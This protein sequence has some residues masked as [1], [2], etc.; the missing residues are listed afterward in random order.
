M[1]ANRLARRRLAAG[2]GAIAIVAMGT[3]SACAGEKK[4]APATTTTT[5]TTTTTVSPSE[6]GLSPSGVNKFTPS[7]K[8]PGPQT[9]LPGNVNTG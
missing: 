3:L 4:E 1:K 8:A 2:V 9:A 5:T 6:K 7:V